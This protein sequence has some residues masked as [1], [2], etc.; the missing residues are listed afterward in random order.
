MNNCTFTG[1]IVRDAEL[2]YTQGGMAI[3]SFTLAVD[4]GYGEKKTTAFLG[5]T[6]FG[7]RAESL[8]QHLT[9][10]SKVGVV[11][12]V[13]QSSWEQDGEKRSKIEFIVNDVE[14]MGGAKANDKPYQ[15]KPY[16]A[17]PELFEG[18]D[19]DSAIPF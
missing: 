2:R 1:N 7:K 3:A 12:E 8:V 5:M 11:A 16:H 10:G 18:D 15:P 17:P 19:L 9:K 4:R 14:L 6:L 13:S